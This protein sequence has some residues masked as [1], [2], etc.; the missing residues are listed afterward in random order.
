MPLIYG[1]ANNLKFIKDDFNRAVSAPQVLLAHRTLAAQA[2]PQPLAELKRKDNLQIAEVASLAVGR[3]PQ[4]APLH[5]GHSLHRQVS[6]ENPL[7]VA[8]DEAEQVR[9]RPPQ[10]R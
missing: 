4:A 1:L 2:L 8:G 3:V 5:D 9:L 6:L 10:Y 7:R